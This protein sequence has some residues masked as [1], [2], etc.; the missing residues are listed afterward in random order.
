MRPIVTAPLR[1]PVTLAVLALALSCGPSQ[2][3]TDTRMWSDSYELRI[4]TDPLPPRARERT[5]YKIVVRDK[6]SKQP[7]DGGQG[8]IYATNKD[9]RSIWDSMQPG[10]EVGTY[11]ATLNFITAGDW[12]IAAEFRSDSTKRLEK[13]EWRQDV[14]AARGEPAT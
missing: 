13:M 9:Q 12:A 8:V 2:P 5:L 11:Y 14:R 1:H 7:V 10:P 6:K 4:S 3:N